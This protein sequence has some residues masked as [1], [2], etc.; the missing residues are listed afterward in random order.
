MRLNVGI[1]LAL[2]ACAREPIQPQP[3]P[4]I[5]ASASAQ[6]AS[7]LPDID[8]YDIDCTDL[9]GRTEPLGER[10][11]RA[12]CA[13]DEFKREVT[14]RYE[15]LA[16]DMFNA[17]FAKPYVWQQW[18]SLP[19][20][21]AERC[22]PPEDI[23]QF[24]IIDEP[25]HTAA[26]HPSNP[27]WDQNGNPVRFDVRINPN[28]SSH[29][30]DKDQW[31]LTTRIGQ[32]VRSSCK[33]SSSNLA[34]RFHDDR[35]NSYPG[36]V[37]LKF[38]WRKI[39]ADA[40]CQQY[41]FITASG[42]DCGVG[43]EGL[44]ALHIATKVKSGGDM[45]LWATFSHENNTLEQA[46]APPP[47]FRDPACTTCVDNQC[48]DCTNGPCRTQIRRMLE[49]A[50]ALTEPLPHAASFSRYELIGVQRIPNAYGIHDC[51]LA[52]P[53]PEKVSNE[54]LEWDR[55]DSSCLGCHAHA[56]VN[57]LAPAGKYDKEKCAALNA[58]RSIDACFVDADWI[59]HPDGKLEI[60]RL[61]LKDPDSQ[62]YADMFWLLDS[63]Q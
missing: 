31:S 6:P 43:E 25:V 40:E 62:Y 63:A 55:Q 35:G 10:C 11:S 18:E 8:V 5:D 27:I 7:E 52:K 24:A 16:S 26:P 19:V 36:P 14:A 38:A 50:R 51:D 45:W 60:R 56:R 54:I 46:G 30:A 2:V 34:W 59:H 21:I 37:H 41:G 4:V 29:I 47:L 12:S 13:S 42:A 22:V 58:C 23:E 49:P 3:G 17:L 33:G 28:A 1:F 61:P 44:V 53:L 32:V 15:R 57:V 48:P 9:S 20:P 39:V